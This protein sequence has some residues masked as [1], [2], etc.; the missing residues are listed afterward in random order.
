MTRD[1]VQ[2]EARKWLRTPYRKRGRSHDGVDCI[3]FL[4]MVGRA[5]EV[6]H[7]DE[8]DYSTWPAQDLLILKKLDQYLDRLPPSTDLPGTIGVFAEARLPGHVGIFS[9]KERVVHLIHARIHPGRV[10][11]EP[12]GQVP[13]RE[14]RLIALFGF[15]GLEP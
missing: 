12:W 7:Q 10:I 3:G 14:L 4:V 9:L 1:E 5:F 2:A 6:P 13:R 11:E 15:P 8:L